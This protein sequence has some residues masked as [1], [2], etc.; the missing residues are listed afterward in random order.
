MSENWL[1]ISPTSG[2]GSTQLMIS[3]DTNNTGTAR[4]AKI[5]ITAGTM[6]RTI[7]VVQEVDVVEGD[8]V[9]V[10]QQ[11]Y[12]GVKLFNT[13]DYVRWSKV[14]V[15]S[16]YGS[17]TFTGDSMS[18]TTEMTVYSFNGLVPNTLTAKIYYNENTDANLIDGLFN[19]INY[20]ISIS[21][22]SKIQKING[23]S[24]NSQRLE[25]VYL[26]SG[27]T[28]IPA[29]GFYDSPLYNCPRLEEFSG[30]SPLIEDSRSLVFNE[31]LVAFAPYNITEYSV[32]NTVTKTARNVFGFGNPTASTYAL[33][34]NRIDIPESVT[35]MGLENA[36]QNFYSLTSITIPNSVVSYSETR[37]TFDSC[38][39]L[40]QVSLSTAI[41]TYDP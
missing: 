32:P 14:V 39:S 8:I 34:I 11:S 1:H 27:V 5:I 18:A 25:K 15:S 31:C 33:T 3:A 40:T 6:T 23:L 22:L 20:V 12:F 37:N 2:H 7:D 26:Y 10:Y 28:E 41:T 29:Y 9:A 21:I 17:I 19:N 4:K 36:F 30:E 38:T 13:V 16:E 35:Q 24:N